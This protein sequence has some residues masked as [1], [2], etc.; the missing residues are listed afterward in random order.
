VPIWCRRILCELTTET[1]EENFINNWN[2]RETSI[3]GMHVCFRIKERGRKEKKEG[4]V[5]TIGNCKKNVK[6]PT[7]TIHREKKIKLKKKNKSGVKAHKVDR[8][9]IR[10]TRMHEMHI[11]DDDI[12]ESGFLV[13]EAALL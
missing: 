12:T 13:K 7:P 8:Q 9:T 5:S 2:N 11:N 4:S 3:K 1:K 10:K 6:K